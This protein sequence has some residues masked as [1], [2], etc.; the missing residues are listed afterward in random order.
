MQLRRFYFVVAVEHEDG[1]DEVE[2][3]V[4]DVTQQGALRKLKAEFP[5]FADITYKFSELCEE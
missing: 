1:Y 2:A 3:S 5:R 4:V